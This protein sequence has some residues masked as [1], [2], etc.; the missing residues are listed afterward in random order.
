MEQSKKKARVPIR[1]ESSSHGSTEAS[2]EESRVVDAYR[3]AVA[4]EEVDWQEVA[5]RLKAEM[6][7]YRKRQRRW[8][9]DQILSE[10]SDL[11][12]KFLEV[13]DNLEYALAHID[14]GD[15]AHR[16]VQVAYDAVLS[17]LLREGVER[18]F[19]KG[20]PF[21]P[22]RHDAVAVVPAPADQ[23]DDLKVIDVTSEGY[24]FEDRVLR[25]AK[26]VVAK[27]G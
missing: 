17:L 19:A 11:L 14:S 13:V 18:I 22:L 12:R 5:K 25:P 7:N 26:V 24:M 16:G 1:R 3:P 20:H 21:D 9:E 23:S 10:K 2:G 27:R 4:Q 6:E 8:A 15:P